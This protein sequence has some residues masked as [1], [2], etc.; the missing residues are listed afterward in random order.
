MKKSACGVSLTKNKVPRCGPKQSCA[1]ANFRNL[2][3]KELPTIIF[4]ENIQ[5]GDASVAVPCQSLE[6]ETEIPARNKEQIILEPM[7]KKKHKSVRLGRRLVTPY[8]LS[9]A[10]VPCIGLIAF[11]RAVVA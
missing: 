3:S 5:K 2:A 1:L 11:I 8:S 9:V 10:V 4:C 6:Q 7:K